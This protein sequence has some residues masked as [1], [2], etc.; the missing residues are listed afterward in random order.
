MQWK[1]PRVKIYLNKNV[2]F[3]AAVNTVACK[4]APFLVVW[5]GYPGVLLQSRNSLLDYQV[6]LCTED[7]PEVMET[8]ENRWKM[9]KF[10]RD[11]FTNLVGRL[12]LKRRSLRSKKLLGISV[13]DRR[14]IEATV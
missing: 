14:S 4:T 8:S 5:S 3:G 7:L 12:Y 10:C 13:C 11:Y 1:S 6:I 2:K 9:F